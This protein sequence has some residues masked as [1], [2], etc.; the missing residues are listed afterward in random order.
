MH[1]ELVGETILTL[2][3]QRKQAVTLVHNI[4]DKSSHFSPFASLN[5]YVSGLKVGNFSTSKSSSVNDGLY[6][7]LKALFFL[8]IVTKSPT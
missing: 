2:F 1:S 4:K 6:L 7:F 8:T 3:S 5:E